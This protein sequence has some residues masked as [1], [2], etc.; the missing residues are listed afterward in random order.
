[1]KVIFSIIEHSHHKVRIAHGITLVILSVSS[2]EAFPMS[3]ALTHT[4]SGVLS[5]E[6]PQVTGM[7]PGFQFYLWC[8]RH[9]SWSCAQQYRAGR[10]IVRV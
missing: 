7:S 6:E 8:F 2:W 3:V 4:N 5:L 1:M 10:S 9:C